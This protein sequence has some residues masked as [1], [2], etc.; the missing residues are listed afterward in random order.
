[1]PS[2]ICEQQVRA[3]HPLT[4]I[5]LNMLAGLYDAQGKYAEAELLNWRALKN[6]V[7]QLRPCT[8]F[9]RLSILLCIARPRVLRAQ[10]GLSTVIDLELAYDVRDIVAHGFGTDDQALGDLRVFLALRQ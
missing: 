9:F 8:R 6:R 5:S 3:E 2:S 10:D 1:M 7:Q 4:A